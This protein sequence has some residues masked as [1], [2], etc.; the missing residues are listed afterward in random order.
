MGK[1]LKYGI[2]VEL[3]GRAGAQ[4]KQLGK[5]L[6]DLAGK[7]R[8]GLGAGLG[9]GFARMFGGGV[10]GRIAGA[11]ATRPGGIGGMLSDLIKGATSL[12]LIPVRILNSF[13]SLIPGVGGILSGVVG[14]AA[15]ILQG[16]VGIAANIAGAVLNVVA[17]LVQ[18]IIGAIESIIGAVASVL[19]KVA[20]AAVV[21]GLGIGAA[22]GAAMV[23]GIAGNLAE[24]RLKAVLKRRLGAGWE[25][26][27]KEIARLS[28]AVGIAEEELAG[29][30]VKLARTDLRAPAQ[31]LQVIADAAV[32]AGVS[33]GEVADLFVQVA[34]RGEDLGRAKMRLFEL[35][36]PAETIARIK[37]VADLAAVLAQRFGGV[38]A[39]VARLSP[40]KQ[41]W[42]AFWEDVEALTEALTGALVPALNNVAAWLD[43]LR[44]S[45]AFQRLGEQVGQIGQQIVAAFEGAWTWLTTRDWGAV[46][47]G[48]KDTVANLPGLVVESFADIRTLAEATLGLLANKAMDLIDQVVA[49][50]SEHFGAAVREWGRR[51]QGL[52]AGQMVE[53]TKGPG[54]WGVRGPGG[55][56]VPPT[57][58]AGNWI[59]AMFERLTGPLMDPLQALRFR[60]GQAAEAAGAGVIGAAAGA[61]EIGA[62]APERAAARGEENTQLLADMLAV[63]QRIEGRAGA[64]AAP[65]VA[66]LMA[67][68][69]LQQEAG[70]NEAIAAWFAQ[71]QKL[72]QEF[73]A[74]RQLTNAEVM[75]MQQ[76]TKIMRDELARMKAQLKHLSQART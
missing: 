52:G 29:A 28:P 8:T 14:T 39:E 12:A 63:L 36:I 66:P 41:I 49:Y 18:K 20:K 62:A 64:A 59:S 1:D 45:P 55:Q 10:G 5:D 51:L 16:L 22:V 4:I 27:W 65:V 7:L 60:A 71:E 42:R 32:G 61:A 17:G 38:A 58:R 53:A 11:L 9:G 31:Y 50:L 44:D 37:N 25:A 69:P 21:A 48:F 3:K 74:D 72:W 26:A 75:A 67:L 6:G 34:A 2:L 43:R 24:M 30:L 47:Q 13:A 70:L 73:L 57:F 56:P 33:L 35:G 46:W 76:F 40:M 19:G 54:L 68:T 23:K 15:N